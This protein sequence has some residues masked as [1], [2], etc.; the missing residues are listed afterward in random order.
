MLPTDVTPELIARET[1]RLLA[2]ASG[3]SDAAVRAPSLCDGW[4]RGHVLTHVARNADGLVRV[5]RAI[6]EGT[7][8]TM[9][10]AGDARDAEIEAGQ[11]RSAAELAEDVRASAGTLAPW[12][13]RLRAEHVGR[14]APRTPGG[15]GVPAE[16]VRYMRLRELVYHH[17]DL[18]AGFSFDDVDGRLVALFLEETVANLR[19]HP[20]PPGLRLTSEEGDS[21]VVGDGSS[22]VSGT[23]AGLLGWLSRGQTEQVHPDGEL[24][25][26]PA[27]V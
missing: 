20:A 25:P 4:T 1:D 9:Y 27:G 13:D 12:L 17:V 14:S 19:R 22:E 3:L 5:C 16:R 11:G 26:V 7:D 8:E 24:P 18:D 2:T 10:A 6:T 23:R 15:P 21:Y